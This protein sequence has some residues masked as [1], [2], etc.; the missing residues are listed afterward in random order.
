M[1][2]YLERELTELI[3]NINQVVEGRKAIRLVT[4][5]TGSRQVQ[6]VSLNED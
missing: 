5:H 6:F 4:N 1:R 2:P 3:K